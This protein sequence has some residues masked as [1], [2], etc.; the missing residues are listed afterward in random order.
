M[1]TD[2]LPSYLLA[3]LRQDDV[4]FWSERLRDHAM[5]LYILLDP[6]QASDLRER[7]QQALNNWNYQLLDP[8][9]IVLRQLIQN[10][11]TLK[12]DI[13]ERTRNGQINLLLSPNDF[14]ALVRHMM[15]ELNFFD[16]LLNGQISAQEELAFWTEE[17]A[18]HTELTAHLL[19]PGQSQTQ[20]LQLAQQ[21]QQLVNSSNFNQLLSV[22]HTSNQGAIELDRVIQQQSSNTVSNVIHIMLEHEIKEGLRGEQRIHQLLRI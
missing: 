2:T 5:I 12:Q 16:K 10:L 22:Y 19:S 17:N 18:Q 20:N 6:Q 8:N 13:L 9:P 21:L 3:V 7:A 1:N 15:T 11:A 14:Q 4:T